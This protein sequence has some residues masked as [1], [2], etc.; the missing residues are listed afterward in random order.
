MISLNLCNSVGEIHGEAPG[1]NRTSRVGL[2]RFL[3]T[4]IRHVRVERE[5]VAI[6]GMSLKAFG[7]C[8]YSDSQEI[9]KSYEGPNR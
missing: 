9:F 5:D 8:I 1:G 3:K 4:A 2:K 7:K 6:Q